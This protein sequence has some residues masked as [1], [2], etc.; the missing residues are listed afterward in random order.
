MGRKSPQEKKILSY[1]KDGRNSY[2]ESDKGARKR[3]PRRKTWVNRTMRHAVTQVLGTAKRDKPDA[4]ADV[5]T[6]TIRRKAWKKDAD[7]ALV[8][9]V[10]SSLQQRK[11]R[12][13]IDAV[14]EP[15]PLQLEAKRRLRR[16]RS[17]R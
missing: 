8:H 6:T 16:R 2:G 11:R 15:S 17:T 7:L 5:D 1:E 9:V 4:I 12:K 14:P 13:I 3:I 10:E